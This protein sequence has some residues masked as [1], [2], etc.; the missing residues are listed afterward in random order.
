[1]LGLIASTVEGIEMLEEYNWQGVTTPVGRATGIC[2]P[3]DLRDFVEVSPVLD[4]SRKHV[5]YGQILQTEPWQT[6][7]PLIPSS[8]FFPTPT[9]HLEVSLLAALANLSNHI[10]ATQASKTLARLK[11]RHMALF[12]DA[13]LWHRAWEM[14]GNYH[15]RSSVRRYILELFD[16]QLGPDMVPLLIEADQELREAG[17]RTRGHPSSEQYQGRRASQPAAALGIDKSVK[18]LMNG[19]E[20]VSSDDDMGDDGDDDEESTD[21]EGKAIMPVQ[22]LQPVLSVKGFLL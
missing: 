6:P 11:H 4:G 14:L 16:L 7:A 13:Q 17:A 18:A 19:V 3:M 22:V 21:D 2:V 12:S 10:L 1:M 15:Y 20:D 8:V 5:T 9:N